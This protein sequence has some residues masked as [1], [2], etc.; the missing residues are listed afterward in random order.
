M[1][2]IEALPK[3]AIA[4]AGNW[5]PDKEHLSHDSTMR[6]LALGALMGAGADFETIAFSGGLL[7]NHGV[8]E[9]VQQEEDFRAILRRQSI[10][11]DA[12]TISDSDCHDT[13]K[14]ARNL[15]SFAAIRDNRQLLITSRSHQSRA[16]KIFRHAGVDVIAYDAESILKDYGTPEQQAAAEAHLHSPQ[17][18][19]RVLLE[20]AMR[21]VL[22]V[23]PNGR[24][25][26]RLASTARA[27]QFDE[28][29]E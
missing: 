5:A 15:A 24:I 23:D 10:T 12:V 2:T 28:A 13:H 17:Y 11:T 18:Y 16:T 3:R 25:N 1:I 26:E 19:K 27:G 9:A 29:L 6:L 4:L 8:T 14:S 22:L 21:A 7:N 20:T